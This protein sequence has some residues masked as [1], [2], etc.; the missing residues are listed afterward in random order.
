MEGGWHSRTIKGRGRP[1]WFLSWL[2]EV[3]LPAQAKDPLSS[4]LET[5]QDAVEKLLEIE[6]SVKKTLTS[7]FT[8]EARI[9]LTREDDKNAISQLLRTQKLPAEKRTVQMP[10]QD[11]SKSE[12]K[13]ISRAIENLRE[14]DFLMKALK[15]WCSHFE[16][17]FDKF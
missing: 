10:W 3:F 17:L 11:L 15:H 12:M 7:T 2:Q 6:D 16:G 9:N 1:D 5:F 13:I 14:Q 4:Q 8:N